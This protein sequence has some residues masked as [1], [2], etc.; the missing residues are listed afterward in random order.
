MIEKQIGVLIFDGFNMLD[1]AGPVEVF[2]IA[3]NVGNIDYQVSLVGL[4]KTSYPS[5]SGSKMLADLSINDKYNFDTL[6]IPG[7]K[8][9]R[10]QDNHAL[11]KVWLDL[12]L[13]QCR[14]VVSVCTG[15]YMLASTGALDCKEAT[16]IGIL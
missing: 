16:L 8:G 4:E 1:V 11:H 15:S 5:E 10:C 7:G 12:M 9:A 14:R 6:I 13:T 2:N 3:K